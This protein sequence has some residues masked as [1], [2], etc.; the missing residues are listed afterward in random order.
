[1]INCH[2]IACFDQV[3]ETQAL[4]LAPTRE[5]AVQIQKVGAFKLLSIKHLQ[6]LGLFL[7]CSPVELKAQLLLFLSV[8]KRIRNS[9]KGL[10]CLSAL[11]PFLLT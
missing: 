4:I 3:R 7:K 9:G 1:V 8:L 2:V 6:G 11:Y 5:L 10:F